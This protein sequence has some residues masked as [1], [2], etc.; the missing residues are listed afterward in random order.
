MS[1][2]ILD[3]DNIRMNELWF[4]IKHAIDK[5]ER[6]L[7]DSILHSKEMEEVDY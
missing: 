7:V 1:G 5:R 6:R 3:V 4:L 2:T